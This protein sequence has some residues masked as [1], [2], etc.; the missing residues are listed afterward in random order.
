MAKRCLAAH[1]PPLPRVIRTNAWLPP[2]QPE[3]Q[4]ALWSREHLTSAQ[5]PAA[6]PPSPPGLPL[7]RSPD[8]H[9]LG[10]L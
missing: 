4:A 9:G 8:P 1:P 7:T 3:A 10:Q 2:L 5:E 6:A